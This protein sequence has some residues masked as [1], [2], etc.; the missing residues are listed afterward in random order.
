M[1]K[2]RIDSY[3]F[4]NEV[5]LYIVMCTKKVLNLLSRIPK[6]SSFNT[7]KTLCNTEIVQA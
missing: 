2:K 7:H 3:V 1:Q 5:L 4:N 6:I